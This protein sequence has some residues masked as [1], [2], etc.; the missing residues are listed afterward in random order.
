MADFVD[1]SM[2]EEQFL[3]IAQSLVSYLLAITRTANYKAEIRTHA[4]DVFMSCLDSLEMLT[5][6][7][8]E[9]IRVFVDG[10][11]PPWLETIVAIIS[12][13]D[14]PTNLKT[15]SLETILKLR[16][17]FPSQLVQYLP[18]IFSPI[19]ESLHA[20]DIYDDQN[21]KIIE[22]QVEFL[23]KAI[24]AKIVVEE[25][26][27]TKATFEGCIALALKFAQITPS[28]TE[29]W[30]M[31]IEGFVEDLEETSFSTRHLSTDLVEDLMK[32]NPTWTR[33]VIQSAIDHYFRQT[34]PTENLAREQEA[35]V[36]ILVSI[37]EQPTQWQQILEISLSSTDVFLSGRGALYAAQLGI[38]ACFAKVVEQLH[39]N[40]I[41][42]RLCATKA[43]ARYTET[44]E[45][46]V[47]RE[48]TQILDAIF[49][50]LG[51]VPPSALLMVAESLSPIIKIAPSVVLTSQTPLQGLFALL[52]GNPG[53]ISL[54]STV[55]DIF[56][57]LAGEVDFEALCNAVLPV[58][59]KTISTE[60][61]LRPIAFDILNGIIEGSD[62][63]LPNN[64]VNTIWPI[65]AVPMEIEEQ[66]TVHEILR[67]LV[68]KAWDQVEGGGHISSLLNIIAEAFSNGDE[69]T[70]FYIPQLVTSLIRQSGARLANIMP[71]LLEIIVEKLRS[72]GLSTAYQQNLISVFAEIAVTQAQP[73][74]EFLSQ[75]QGL[76][77][78]MRTWC[79]VFPDFHGYASIRTSVVGLSQI[80]ST[81][82]PVLASIEVKGD[83]IPDTSGKILTRSRAKNNPDRYTS[84][85]LPVKIVKLFL[86]ELI[87]EMEGKNDDDEEVV[88]DDEWEG[89]DLSKIIEE[90]QLDEAEFNRLS[91]DEDD[92]LKEINTRQHIIDFLSTRIASTQGGGESVIGQLSIGEQETLHSVLEIS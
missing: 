55:V 44:Q 90:A 40:D 91:E 78:V 63:A 56:E 26:L 3:P 35:L 71:K 2:S 60:E 31:D 22:L 27:A 82:L 73:L 10:A 80:Y 64:F 79:E 36:F 77:I 29:E 54:V 69:S 13:N 4:I 72:P 16:L 20:A 11:L 70:S 47:S 6:T 65:F 68:K 88:S 12:S 92:S 25:T 48:Q 39:S 66:Q 89:T 76:D 58:I 52:A 42:V 81:G 62:N 32:V 86:V 75:L 30:T 19:Y 46:L 41:V 8:R 33:E 85:P 49:S 24:Q 57:S 53:D 87:N 61:I 83:L 14:A 17:L 9:G 23:R 51:D 50:T 74:V 28:L 59:L 45:S 18:A 7:R 15:K 21:S 43:V 5:S 1:D 37:A 84:V 34:Q 38:A 67:N